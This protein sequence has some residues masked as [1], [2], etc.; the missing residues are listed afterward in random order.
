[1]GP[2]KEVLDFSEPDA[3]RAPKGPQPLPRCQGCGGGEAPSLRS[4]RWLHRGSGGTQASAAG[5]GD[6][7]GC[8][9]SK[10]GTSLCIAAPAGDY[11]ITACA[12]EV[13]REAKTTKWAE[14]RLSHAIQAG[15]ISSQ[16]H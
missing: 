5:R 7:C 3:R 6:L 15:G 13:G 16:G 2:E 12:S 14:A 4:F 10:E 11:G 9:T 1:M 8:G